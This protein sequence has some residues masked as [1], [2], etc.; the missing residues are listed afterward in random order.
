MTHCCRCCW[1]FCR[2][3]ESQLA[4]KCP[5]MVISEKPGSR[6][7]HH[8]PEQEGAN[9]AVS[10]LKGGRPHD[11]RTRNPGPAYRTSDKTEIR[12]REQEPVPA[13]VGPVMETTV[14]KAKKRVLP[15]WMVARDMEPRETVSAVRPKRA[16]KTAMARTVTV[17]CMN[18]AELVDVALSILAE[19]RKYKET[20]GSVPSETEGKQEGQQMPTEPQ[21]SPAS[22]SGASAPRPDAQPDDLGCAS[23]TDTEDEEDDALKYVREIFFS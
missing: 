20:E 13:L 1:A 6:S 2:Q 4:N 23:R 14:C 3:R 10:W 8:F 16:K 7:E 17:Y 18:E 9:P 5:P 11:H 15:P 12:S 19:N 21:K 22:N